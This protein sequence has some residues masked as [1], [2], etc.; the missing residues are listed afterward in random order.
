LLI[1]LKPVI[2]AAHLLRRRVLR[3]R[4][5]VRSLRVGRRRGVVWILA[6][7]WSRSIRRGGNIVWSWNHISRT[8]IPWICCSSIWCGRILISRNR[9]HNRSRKISLTRRT[10][11]SRARKCCRRAARGQ[12]ICVIQARAQRVSAWPRRAA[13]SRAAGQ[14]L[15]HVLHRIVVKL[16]QRIVHLVVY[17]FNALAFGLACNPS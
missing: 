13:E 17:N 8:R 9:R 12:S 11:R 3:R 14:T 16:P 6:I 10:N 1:D 5:V 4:I 7:V 2:H 15:F